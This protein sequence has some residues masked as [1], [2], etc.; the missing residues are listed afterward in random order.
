MLYCIMLMV[1]GYVLSST[2]N[3]TSEDYKSP[4]GLLPSSD[5]IH[6]AA[7]DLTDSLGQPGGPRPPQQ[8]EEAGGRAGPGQGGFPRQQGG[9]RWSLQLLQ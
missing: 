2:M 8:T 4:P 1:N 9:G 5:E 7:D 3:L 6:H